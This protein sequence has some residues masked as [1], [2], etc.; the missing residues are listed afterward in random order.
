MHRRENQKSHESPP[1]VAGWIM[2]HRPRHFRALRSVRWNHFTCAWSCL[3]HRI[4]LT[5]PPCLRSVE[6][7][8]GFTSFHCSYYQF[9]KVQGKCI[10]RGRNLLQLKH[11]A[12]RCRPRAVSMII[13][14]CT[15]SVRCS[16]Q[17]IE[18]VNPLKR[19]GWTLRVLHAWIFKKFCILT[20]VC[21]VGYS[22][23]KTII[24]TDCF[25]FIM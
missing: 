11:V 10:Y 22:E 15:V 9:V 1:A 25:I 24:S 21:L 2:G 7:R 6:R 3:L 12:P 8:N 5:W 14:I 17:I 4:T 19:S 23:L 18:L 13:A 20:T 16:L